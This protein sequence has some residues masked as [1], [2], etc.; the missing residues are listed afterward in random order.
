MGEGAS[1]NQNT[2]QLSQSI[3]CYCGWEWLIFVQLPL[4][5]MP[6]VAGG[7]HEHTEE[8][9]VVADGRLYHQSDLDRLLAE[10]EGSVR[11]TA[12]RE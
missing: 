1:K 12:S 11:Q 3:R 4:V 5:G 2:H 9:A 6:R 10:G 7:H 8:P